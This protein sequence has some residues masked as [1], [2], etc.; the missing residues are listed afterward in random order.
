LASFEKDGTGIDG[1]QNITFTF[2]G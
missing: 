1:Q 2:T